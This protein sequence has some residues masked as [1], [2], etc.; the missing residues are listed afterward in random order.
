[1]S[2]KPPDLDELMFLAGEGELMLRDA[3]T[4]KMVPI[5]ELEK[6]LKASEQK[7]RSLS[8]HDASTGICWWE[9][10][11]SKVVFVL[12]VVKNSPADLS[13]IQTGDA[14]VKVIFLLFSATSVQ[15]QLTCCDPDRRR[16]GF[17]ESGFTLHSKAYSWT[18]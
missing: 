4:G 9:D 5:S 7:I 17:Q 6:E 1:M 11:K 12:R 15:V 10:P 13:R 18:C 14:L 2:D 8:H 16:E 3:T